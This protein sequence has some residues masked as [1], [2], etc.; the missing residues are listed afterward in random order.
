M[1]SE[2]GSKGMDYAD[3]RTYDLKGRHTVVIGRIGGMCPE[4]V[5][6]IIA[7]KGGVL[8]KDVGNDT[9]LVIIGNS[10]RKTVN[11][12]RMESLVAGG[13]ELFSLSGDAFCDAFR[14]DLEENPRPLYF[15]TSKNKRP[16]R[17][18]SV[19]RSPRDYV[20]LDLETTGLSPSS[21]HIIEMA[22]YRV[23]DGQVTDRFDTLVDP[24]HRI[25]SF[26]TELTGITNEMVRGAPDIVD[27]LPQ[28]FSFIG[29]DMVVGH[30]VSFDMNFLYDAAIACEMDPVPND[31]IDT[32]RL[33]RRLYP[34]LQKHTLNHL[35]GYLGVSMPAHRAEADVISTVECYE[36]M[37]RDISEKGL[38]LK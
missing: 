12:R 18:S 13:K 16:G 23:R 5:E 21:D 11:H 29:S 38:K 24:G 15:K 14:S 6:Y 10:K 35:A 2:D 33:S 28:M 34:D 8:M 25:S 20:C 19:L 26:I 3:I 27:A 17:G 7:S 1:S 32:M 30:N 22:A 37:F 4:D 31:F 36:I 9:D